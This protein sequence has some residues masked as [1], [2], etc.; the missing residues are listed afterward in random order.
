MWLIVSGTQRQELSPHVTYSSY[1]QRFDIE[2]MLRFSK[3]RLLMTQFQTQRLNT[4][5]TGYD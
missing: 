4:K 2:H 3:Q 1:R 5:R